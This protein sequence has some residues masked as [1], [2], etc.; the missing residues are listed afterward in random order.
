MNALIG[1]TLLHYRIL[2]QIGSGG[3]G[4]VY[5]AVDE[6][7]HREVALKVLPPGLLADESSRKRFHR[8]ALAL[9]RLSHP[10]ICVVHDFNTQ[11]GVDFLVMELLHGGTLADRLLDGPLPENEAV[12]I[13]AQIAEALE[14]AH[15]AGVVHWDLKPGN[16]MVTERGDVKVLD[17][18]LARRLRG[19]DSTASSLS[20]TG[21]QEAIAGT[22][23][24]MAPEQ[25][26]GGQT[27]AR[28]DLWALGVVLY[29]TI[30]GRRPFQGESPMALA[31]DI[32]HRQ[33]A[34]PRSVRRSIAPWLEAV[35][36]R[37]LRKKPAERYPT[38]SAVLLDLH[39]ARGPARPMP[40][41]RMVALPILATAL[42]IGVGALLL[43]RVIPLPWPERPTRI[44]SIAVLPLENLSGKP[45]QEY[46]VDGMT[47]EIT[48]ALAQVGALRV[49]SRTSAMQFKG[50]QM[51]LPAI[52]RELKADAIVQGTVRETP[53][54]VLI[55]AQLVD[56]ATDRYLWAQNFQ[57][58]HE[59]VLA[60]QNEI[61][62]SIAE[63]IRIQ[64]TPEERV[65]LAAAPIIDA[66][67][68]DA[69]LRGRFFYNQSYT[70]DDLGR[71]MKE[72]RQAIAIDPAYA[73]AYAGLAETYCQLSSTVLP[74]GEAMPKAQAAAERA[75][76]ID[77]TLASAHASLAYVQAFYNWNWKEGERGFR[78]ALELGPS[79]ATTHQNYG[80]LLNNLGRFEEAKAE[81]RRAAELDPLS[82]F[83]STQQLYPLYASRHYDEV[84]AAA[85][86]VLE[87]DSNAAV[88]RFVRAQA[89]LGKGDRGVAY[90]EIEKAYASDPQPGFLAYLGYIS[91][92]LGQRSRAL[93][94]MRELAHPKSGRYVQPYMMA[95]VS[96]GLGDKTRAFSWIRKGI[97]ERSE[98]TAYIKVDPIMEPLRSDPRYRQ[99]MRLIGFA[100]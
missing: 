46:F 6:R 34:R 39:R 47:D 87:A 45:D 95:V 65:R 92:I 40:T 98:E 9:S 78:R 88:A 51:S 32:L 3:M 73:R 99:I 5:R 21:T 24:Y 97:E 8:E 84:I 62:R 36:L 30:T 81:L 14:A 70:A 64:V 76:E 94:I 19:F 72:Y 28:V 1:K 15:E 83:I 79:E 56:G 100:S 18:G 43:A 68:H 59:N 20:S 66:R 17:F 90:R 74:A 22:I 53:D 96:I 41:L 89:Y 67:A 26:A 80:Y 31:S 7:L 50:K 63:Q 27:D 37:C 91:G 85:G 60:L 10:R 44:L 11:D 12:R 52:A 38:A 69:Y 35:I 25:L 93:E 13:G 33:P 48:N 75:L 29:E 54:V 82:T 16:I 57:R 49:I 42:A 4:V 71:A 23:P 55:S 86:K 61:A 58:A 77:T 2:E